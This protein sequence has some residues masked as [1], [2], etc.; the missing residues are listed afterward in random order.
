MFGM[1]GLLTILLGSEP[2]PNE[3][4][5]IL[6]VCTAEPELCKSI[7][8]QIQHRWPAAELFFVAPESFRPL[9]GA[10]AKTY[11]I[12]VLKKNKLGSLLEIRRQRF[13]ATVLLL[14]GT[15]MFRKLKLWAFL[16]NYRVLVIYNENADSFCCVRGRWYHV[17][18]HM[19]FR[20]WR[21]DW[22]NSTLNMVRWLAGKLA[23][24]FVLCYLVLFAGWVHGRR[25]LLSRVESPVGRGRQAW[26]PMAKPKQH[27]ERKP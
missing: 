6:F 24:P 7:S 9:L 11:A 4:N 14:T 1:R 26:G 25:I 16:T 18:R 12:E 15:P 19:A 8:A 3:V 2:Q 10:P 5:K 20:A 23:L 13:D 17:L 21:H 27:E 22:P